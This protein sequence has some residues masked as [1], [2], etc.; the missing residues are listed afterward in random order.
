MKDLLLRD[1]VHHLL[2]GG[3]GSQGETAAD[4]LGEGDHVGLD[5]EVLAGSAPAQL[6]AGLHLVENEQRALAGADFAQT[7]KVARLR[8]AD[9]D[10]HH[11]GFEDNGRNLAVGFPR[12]GRSWL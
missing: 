12:T 9:A 10:V 3:E 7:L 4:G 11:D 1:H 5:V 8:H 2:A 6:G